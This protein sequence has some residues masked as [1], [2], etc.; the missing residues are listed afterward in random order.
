[1]QQYRIVYDMYSSIDHKEKKKIQN[2]SQL[3]A[4]HYLYFIEKK[5]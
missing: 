5:V 2:L 3:W 4:E 1:M